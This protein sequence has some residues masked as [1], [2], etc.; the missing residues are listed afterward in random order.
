MAKASGD[1]I[2]EALAYKKIKEQVKKG[3]Q[4]GLGKVVTAGLCQDEI[5]VIAPDLIKMLRNACVESIS[6]IEKEVEK[7]M[8][9][10]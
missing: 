4:K 8:A 9:R 7:E 5:K 3:L 6:E 10:K 2:F 1:N